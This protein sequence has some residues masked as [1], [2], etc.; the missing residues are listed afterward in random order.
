V[1][2]LNGLPH[3]QQVDHAVEAQRFE[4]RLAVE[5]GVE[6]PIDVTPDK[7]CSYVI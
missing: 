6:L 4:H 7:C 3:V 1:I 2:R 5:I